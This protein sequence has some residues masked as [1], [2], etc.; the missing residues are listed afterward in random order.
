EPPCARRVRLL[1]SPVH[2]TGPHV[3]LFLVGK[4]SLATLICLPPV[5]LMY[6]PPDV[7]W[8]PHRTTSSAKR[9]SRRPMTSSTMCS[10]FCSGERSLSNLKKCPRVKLPATRVTSSPSS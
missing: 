7:L 3:F 6:Q 8:E 2:R 9:V 10:A 1:V 5:L 4:A